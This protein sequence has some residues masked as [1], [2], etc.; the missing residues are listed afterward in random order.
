LDLFKKMP[1]RDTDE[2]VEILKASGIEYDARFFMVARQCKCFS[3]AAAAVNLA[4]RQPRSE[5][6]Q[7]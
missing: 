5:G 1:A 3:V 4:R 6:S 7:G 2:F